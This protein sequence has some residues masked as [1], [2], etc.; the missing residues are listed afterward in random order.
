M[1]AQYWRRCPIRLSLTTVKIAANRE[2]AWEPKPGYPAK[3]A[4][5]KYD[6]KHD[7]NELNKQA[8]SVIEMEERNKKRQENLA[9][10]GKFIYD[11]DDIE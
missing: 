3:V 11:V 9:K 7:V 10:T 2:F 1:Q 6:P 4:G 8:Q 5:S